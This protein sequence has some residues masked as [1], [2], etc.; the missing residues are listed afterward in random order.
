MAVWGYHTALSADTQGAALSLGRCGAFDEK[1]AV[2]R[3]RLRITQELSKGC[4]LEVDA[5]SR[6]H[7]SLI[8]DEM[9]SRNSSAL[10]RRAN[11][12][13]EH[14]LAGDPFLGS[15]Q[16]AYA[17][18]RRQEIHATLLAATRAESL[19]AGEQ[20]PRS[21][22]ESSEE[23]EE[24]RFT[25][26]DLELAQREREAALGAARP[27]AGERA[28]QGAGGTEEPATSLARLRSE[29]SA[30][31]P[32]EPSTSLRL[33]RAG[34]SRMGEALEAAPREDPWRESFREH[35]SRVE[36]ALAELGAAH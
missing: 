28:E 36:A 8:R 5:I 29:H 4:A 26:W 7:G 21:L 6:S 19:L 18:R 17:S 1:M 35:L 9:L 31:R 11:A 22:G 23:H 25:R 10:L 12:R 20:T 34:V 13:G 15:E 27:Q 30:S 14:H 16:A 33:I 2:L 32:G 24:D 3:E